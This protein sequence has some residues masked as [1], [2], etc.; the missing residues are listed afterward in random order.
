MLEIIEK[1]N[2]IEQFFD[3]LNKRSNMTKNSKFVETVSQI[4]DD[5]LNNGDDA[6]VNYTKKFDDPNFELKNIEVSKEEIKKAYL[7]VDKNI[8][9]ILEEAYDRI[10]KFHVT[11]LRKDY[12]IK[13]EYGTIMGVRYTPIESVG[14]YVPGGKAA[15]PST[16]LMNVVPAKV[17]GCENITMVTPATKGVLNPIVLACA[18]IAKVDHVYRIGGAQAIAALAYGT[19]TIK[20]V[21]KIVGPG[22]IFVALAKREVYGSVGID[23]IAGPSEVCMICDETVNSKYAAADLLAQA[24]H[25]EMASATCFIT[26]K[27]KAEEILKYVNEFYN[28]AARKDILTKS[29]N[30]C[31]KIVVVKDIN[32]AIDYVNRL[33]PEHLEI[34]TKDPMD[35]MAK[36]KNAGSVFLGTYSAESFGDYMMGPNH[37][38]PTSGTAKYFSA[39]GVD[40][41]IKRSTFQ[42]TTKEGAKALSNDV[43]DFATLEGLTMHA[44]SAKL[45]GEE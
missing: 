4:C 20:K 23:S 25:D 21:N 42:Y 38:L 44:L 18:Y 13:D 35:I 41:F 30:N 15:Y 26:S 14:V 31:S 40:D 17:A 2:D 9:R 6:L 3:V 39:L 36:I 24:E 32:K 34:D 16:V 1:E 43:N 37:V 33:A 29:L 19:K 12:S 7:S 8:I 10:Y 28:T 45:R 27:E 5:V 22:N 11:Q